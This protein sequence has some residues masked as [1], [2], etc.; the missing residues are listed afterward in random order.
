MLFFVASWTSGNCGEGV[1]FAFLSNVFREVPVFV[2]RS[3]RESLRVM[4]GVFQGV[5][6]R[7]LIA[8]LRDAIA[9]T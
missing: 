6:L 7:G 2:A 8:L 3:G 1:W 9:R 5:V 4:C